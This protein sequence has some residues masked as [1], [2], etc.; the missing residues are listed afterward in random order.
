MAEKE[1]QG[2]TSKQ[3]K[4]AREEHQAQVQAGATAPVPA[5][6]REPEESTEEA[7]EAAQEVAGQLVDLS[8]A[9]LTRLQGAVG[10]ALQQKGSEPVAAGPSLEEVSGALPRNDE[11]TEEL[12]VKSAAKHFDDLGAEDILGF[13]VRQAQGPSG[14]IGPQYLR[15]VT[16]NGQKHTAKL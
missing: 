1:S 2:R 3:E 12:D 4:E 11:A 16:V 10:R 13:A 8:H 15:V 9:E 6:T 14:P 5:V 7:H